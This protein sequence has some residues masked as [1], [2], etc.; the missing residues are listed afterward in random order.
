MIAHKELPLNEK[1][2]IVSQSGL[3]V[4]T[5]WLILSVSIFILLI[6]EGLQRWRAMKL[7]EKVIQHGGD[8]RFKNSLLAQVDWWTVSP[9]THSFWG[10]IYSVSTRPSGSF[11]VDDIFLLELGNLHSIE[12]L[13]L[14]TTGNPTTITDQ[15][16]IFLKHQ[17][18]RGLGI[19]G[20]SM[21]DKGFNQLAEMNSLWALGLHHLAITGDLL[22]Q[23]SF[24]N[25]KM[26]DLSDTK[27]TDQGLQKLSPNSS[28]VY[29]HL[30]NTCV[31]SAG[32]QELS[33][34]PNLRA[35]RLGNLKI[36]AAAFAKLANMKRLYQLDLQGTAV[37]DAVALQLSQ[38]DQITQLRLDQSQITDQGLRHLATM[39]NLET[40]FLPGAKI[41]DS[42]LKVLSQLPKLDY[43]DLSDTQIS[44]EGLRQLSK[45]PAL[46]MLNL[47]NTR[48]TDQAKQ[49]LLQF[50]ALESIEA[51]D[52]KISPVTI[53]DIRDAGID[54]SKFHAEI[55]PL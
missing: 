40:L 4:R 3:S 27:F 32:L 25:L 48:V 47:S 28:L 29:L 55:S 6:P 38:L 41:T 8:I 44:D 24:P 22:P 45:I 16:A 35:L 36:K 9:Q 50:P 13:A 52:T 51:F 20:G 46:R 43:L 26:L 23:N 34:F 14:G 7:A 54:V 11:Q 31:S 30:S 53:E 21:T 49:I 39:K 5:L 37:N 15:G 18:L 42:G 2:N 19:T 10:S 12:S 17:E 1:P 33:K